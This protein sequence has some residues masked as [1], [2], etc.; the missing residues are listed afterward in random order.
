[1]AL[2]AIRYIDQRNTYTYSTKYARRFQRAG[3]PIRAILF[4]FRDMGGVA[5]RFRYRNNCVTHSRT[6]PKTVRSC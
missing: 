1:M 3:T 2:V 4:F 5:Q 6:V